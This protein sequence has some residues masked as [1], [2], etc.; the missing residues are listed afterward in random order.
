MTEML[1]SDVDKAEMPPG[2]QSFDRPWYWY[3]GSV[4]EGEKCASSECE[5]V[6]HMGLVFMT[7]GNKE[8]WQENQNTDETF[9]ADAVFYCVMHFTPAV[10]RMAKSIR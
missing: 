2:T 9:D 10:E 5:S 4:P 1:Y 7:E 8:R 6:A 3:V